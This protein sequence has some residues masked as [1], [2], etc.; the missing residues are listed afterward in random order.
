MRLR[1]RLKAETSLAHQQLES[2]LDLTQASFGCNDLAQLLARF[3]GYYRVCEDQLSSAPPQLFAE[4]DSRRK[5]SLLG[6]DL[7][8]LGWRDQAIEAIPNCPLEVAT[9]V[10]KVLGRWYVLEGST[11]GGQ[12]VARHFAQ[13]LHLDEACLSFFLSYGEQVGARWRDFCSLLETHSSPQHDDQI[14]AAANDTFRSMSA[15]LT[16]NQF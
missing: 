5:A 13:R 12:Y 16:G 11:L 9:S 8:N 4:L 14:I 1:D 2:R 10:P 15:W 7:R 3:L 6:N